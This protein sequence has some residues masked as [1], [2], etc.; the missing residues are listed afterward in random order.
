MN[1]RYQYTPLPVFMTVPV[2][3]QYSMAPSLVP[4]YP[5]AGRLGLAP[6]A[7]AG[8]C[9]ATATPRARSSPW[10]GPATTSSRYYEPSPEVRPMFV[11]FA[12]SGVDHGHVSGEAR[13]MVRQP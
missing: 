13:M 11:P 8:A 5:L 9:R 1:E 2:H 6:W 12:P 4:L 10:P 3:A 7:R